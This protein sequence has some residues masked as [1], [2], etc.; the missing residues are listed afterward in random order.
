ML[1]EAAEAGMRYGG[2]QYPCIQFLT[3]DGGLV[4]K[5][6]FICRRINT[7]LSSGQQLLAL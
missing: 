7:K 3:A 6:E 2:V 5:R 4:N 1:T